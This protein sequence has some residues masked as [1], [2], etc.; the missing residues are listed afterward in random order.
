MD[1]NNLVEDVVH[2]DN[3]EFQNFLS[4]VY[5]RRANQH[6]PSLS[7]EEADL[8][9]K[10][11]AGFPIE[12]W[13]KLEFLDNKLENSSLSKKEHQELMALTEVYENYTLQ[14][15]KYLAQLADLRKT[16]LREV[17]KQLGIHHASDV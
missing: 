1:L 7:S 10:I 6:A 9:E 3:K 12:Q 8:L 16:T 11:N 15:L 13:Q 2:L 4:V 14:R 17:M 5:N